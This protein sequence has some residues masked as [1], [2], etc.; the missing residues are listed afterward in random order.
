M[1]YEPGTRVAVLSADAKTFLGYGVYL[2]DKDCPPLRQWLATES[3][4]LGFETTAKRFET[5][6]IKKLNPKIRLDNGTEVWGCECWWGG[7]DMFVKSGAAEKMG[8]APPIREEGVAGE[9]SPGVTTAGN[10]PT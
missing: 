5:G 9:T 4:K 1:K 8:V 3:R 7:A 6:E 2:G 10:E